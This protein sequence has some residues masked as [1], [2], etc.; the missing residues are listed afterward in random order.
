[1]A[2]EDKEDTMIFV[3]SDI[4]GYPLDNFLGLLKK[5]DFGV[6]DTLFVLGDVIDRNGDGGVTMLRW[7][8]SQP[9]VDFILG[10]HEAMLLSC[11]FLFEQITDESIKHLNFQQMQLLL[12]W[13]QNGS[14]PTMTALRQLKK[15][16]PEMLGDLLDYLRDAPLY[17]AVSTGG[18]DFLLVHSGLGNFSPSKKL[19]DYSADELLWTRPAPDEKYY[20]DMIT[21]FGHT[22]T[23]Y[24]WGEKG[25]MFRTETWIDIDT[26]ASSGGAPMLLRLDDL[27]AFYAN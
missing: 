20:T 5:A 15:K 8:M 25:K 11:S 1:M 17:A 10:N 14:Q 16:N 18:R 12:Q 22:P 6:N 27:K 23:G 4:H 21:I 2:C 13:M 26:G 3:T 24:I 9:N 7:M 19:S